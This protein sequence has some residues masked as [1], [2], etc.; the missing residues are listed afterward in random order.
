MRL[1]K[2]SAK[3]YRTLENIELDFTTDYCTISGHNNAGKSSVI[4]LLRHL[5]EQPSPGPDSVTLGYDVD[6]TQW[7]KN[8]GPVAVDYRLCLSRADDPALLTFVEKITKRTLSDSV[9]NCDVQIRHTSNKRSQT[10][11]IDAEPVADA[12]SR[13]ILR[14]IRSSNCLFLHNSTLSSQDY[15][16]FRGGRV[17]AAYPILLSGDDY[18]AISDAEK[19]V[20]NTIKKATRVHKDDLENMLGKLR[21]KYTVEFSSPESTSS[22]RMPFDINLNDRSAEVPLGDWGSGTQNRTRILISIL[23]ANRIKCGANIEDRI[24]PIVVIEEPESFLHP[25]AQAEFGSL[26]QALSG[27][28]KIQI[29]ASTH[30]PYMLN[31]INPASNILLRRKVAYKRLVGT[32]VANTEAAEWMAPFAEHLGVI[33]KEFERWRALFSRKGSRVLLVEGETDKEY[34]EYFRKI[35]KAKFNISST[36]EVVPYNGKDALKNLPLIKFILSKLERVFIT[37]DLDARAEVKQRLEAVGLQE[38]VDFAPVGISKPGR[39]AIEGLLPDRVLAAVNGKETDLVMQLQSQNSA[40]RAEAKR[41]LKKKYLEE[42]KKTLTFADNELEL[43]S[44]LA[45]TIAKQL[46]AD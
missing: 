19:K 29:I 30:S 24:T 32:E 44:K 40:Q 6:R 18:R 7:R 37:F 22:R 39:D 41:I 11:T 28:L 31:Q 23:Q 46:G 36:V 20:R 14:K 16:M 26:L 27:E 2:L 38:N 12:D 25:S 21:D 15:F 9:V 43:L 5:L 4:R 34:I 13:E 45:R 33:P 10:V 3:N 8:N 1:T 17:T 35:P 42:F